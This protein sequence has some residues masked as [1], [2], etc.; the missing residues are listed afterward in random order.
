VCVVIIACGAASFEA[1]C[2]SAA[3]IDSPGLNVGDTP[4]LPPESLPQPGTVTASLPPGDG[5]DAVRSRCVACH[6]PAMLRQ[7]RLTAQQWIG[8]I[9]K[10][11][12]WGAPVV[13]E[14]KTR[15]ADYL[16]MIAAPDNSRFTP[17]IVAPLSRESRLRNT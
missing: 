3:E 13:D 8:E 10:M 4:V 2:R 12:G 15:M 1:A 7:Q 17:A 6:D 11:Q 9:E 5:M 14:E 16:A